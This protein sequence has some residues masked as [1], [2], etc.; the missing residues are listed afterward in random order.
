MLAGISL[1]NKCQLL[2]GVAVLV[3]LT[4]ALSVPWVR[5][6]MLVR[7]GQIEVARQAAELWL[8]ER[9]AAGTLDS[10]APA[11]AAGD[12]TAAEQTPVRLFWLQRAR[13]G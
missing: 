1:A 3:I 7:D 10:P 13:F 4:A 5:T 8:T 6:G 9:I 2:F 11:P 12:D